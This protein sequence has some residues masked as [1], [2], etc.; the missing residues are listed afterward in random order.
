MQA[1]AVEGAIEVRLHLKDGLCVA[2]SDSGRQ[3]TNECGGD[4]DD[5]DGSSA[6]GL[7]TAERTGGLLLL[8]GVLPHPHGPS[9]MGERA[10]VQFA[11]GQYTGTVRALLAPQ[12]RI[13]TRRASFGLTTQE[14][15]KVFLTWASSS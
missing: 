13:G 4:D 14:R 3:P 2:D 10:R 9:R 7:E 5:D 15:A 6:C 8:W 1:P 12:P 11:T